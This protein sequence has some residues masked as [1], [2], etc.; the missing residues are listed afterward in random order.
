LLKI[1]QAASRGD[2]AI[3]DMDK[4][5]RERVVCL[6]LDLEKD[7]GEFVDEPSYEGLEHI[8]DLVGFLK[9]RCLPLTCFVQGSLLET[10]RAEIEQLCA[11]G[12][13]FELHSYSHPN[14]RARDMKFEV[15]RGKQSYINFFNKEP[16]GYRSPS[17][18]INQADYEILA[19]NRFRFDSSVFP[20]LRPGTFNNL[21]KPT[22][23]YLLN[24]TQIIEFPFAVFSRVVRIPIALS[25][26]KLLGKL[27]VSFL[28]MANS[29]NLVVF[30][31]HLH[32]LFKLSSSNKIPLDSYSFIYR[33]I[34][35]RIYQDQK[36]N[37]L[38]LLDEVTAALQSKGYIFL[39]LADV[40]EAMSK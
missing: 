6:T 10:H 22:T 15:E 21:R 16:L 28:R 4:L 30:G 39:K 18:V 9:K 36:I 32:D 35:E 34:L 2:Y 26:I 19:A 1:R 25:Y 8:P 29:P 23:P 3:I 38:L 11:L 17:G 5:G 33:K 13:E 12:V 14:P 40:Y 7:Y 37:G 27:W 31:F 24:K 20:S